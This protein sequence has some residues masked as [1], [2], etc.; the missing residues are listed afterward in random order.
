MVSQT[1]VV[2]ALPLD[3]TE[4]RSE[5]DNQMKFDRTKTREVLGHLGA[6]SLQFNEE[7]PE[8]MTCKMD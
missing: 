4:E 8:E 2:C 7:L 3:L 1:D 5:G 6:H